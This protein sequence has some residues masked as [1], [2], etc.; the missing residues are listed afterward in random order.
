M[1]LE[2]AILGFLVYESFTGYD[3]KKVF[4]S[5]VQHFWPADQSQI[6]RTLSRLE[7]KG[8]VTCERIPQEDRPSQ[9]V[10]HITEDGKRVLLD[11]LKVPLPME[12]IRYQFLVQ[13]F[14]AGLLED[15]EILSIFET[16]AEGLRELLK[17]FKVLEREAVAQTQE[18]PKR[19]RYFWLLTLEHGQWIEKAELKWVEKVITRIRNKDY[20]ES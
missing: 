16:K 20:K 1:S 14:F 6:Y 17:S 10:Y 9:K 12:K 4:D 8:Y 15:D 13:V 11:W 5:S 18:Y 3:L 2:N 19:D 7:R